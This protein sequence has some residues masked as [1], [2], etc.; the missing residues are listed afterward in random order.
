MADIDAKKKKRKKRKN[1]CKPQCAGKTCGDDGC[2][3][4]CGECAD[5]LS[6]DGTSCVCPP[7]RTCGAVCCP[8]GELCVGGVCKGPGT[9]QAGDNL[10]TTI[11]NCNGN[12]VCGCLHRLSDN[13][14]F[15]ATGSEV[16]CVA[17]CQTDADCAGFG[18]GSFCV[19]KVGDICCGQRSFPS[20]K[21]SAPCHAQLRA[22]RWQPAYAYS[23]CR[24]PHTCSIW[25]R[26]PSSPM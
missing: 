17:N 14:V 5:N 20:I 26:T 10:C 2:K 16:A 4:S 9:C 19:K 15:C 12:G 7:E 8:A 18:A 24:D 25:R 11:A 23:V 6:C 21:A 13:A 22:G 3:G 1:R